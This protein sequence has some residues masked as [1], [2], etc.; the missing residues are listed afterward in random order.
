[1]LD[2][3]RLIDR[4]QDSPDEFGRHLADALVRAYA[5]HG[6]VVAIADGE[7]AP[8]RLKGVAGAAHD[9]PFRETASGQF[10]AA[11]AALFPREAIACSRHPLAAASAS[12]LVATST[13]RQ[14]ELRLAL[15]GERSLLAAAS[16][17]L[18]G[19]IALVW[20]LYLLALQ[21]RR[22]LARAALVGEAYKSR[23]PNSALYRAASLLVQLFHVGRCAALLVNLGG[24]S[25]DLRAVAP[26]P[27]KLR[28]LSEHFVALG[29]GGDSVV[30]R[31]LSTGVGEVVPSLEDLPDQL[32]GAFPHGEGEL[33]LL[34]LA[35]QKDADRVETSGLLVLGPKQWRVNS[36]TVRGTFL[37]EDLVLL[38]FYADILSILVRALRDRDEESHRVERILHGAKHMFTSVRQN[39][40][41]LEEHDVSALVDRRLQYLLPDSIALIDD[42]ASQLERKRL[43]Q[44][45]QIAVDAE[46]FRFYSDVL[47]GAI[48]FGR[49]LA[50]AFGRTLSVESADEPDARLALP[51]LR[52]NAQALLTVFRNLIHNSVKYARR[53]EAQSWVLVTARHDAMTDRIVAVVSDNGIGIM[54]EDMPHVF[55]DSFRGRNA[56]MVDPGGLGLGLSDCR[57]ILHKL[58]GSIAIVPPGRTRRGLAT[59]SFQVE[60]PVDSRL[61]LEP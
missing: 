8:V 36:A 12:T 53:D 3:I 28:N 35:A 17:E 15:A 27:A 26:R 57:E 10:E 42:L 37:W 23:D 55:E 41:L 59:T 51:L 30:H 52:S 22:L 7:N 1:M 38:E 43:R 25:I 16:A 4:T 56:R 44:L 6:A 29:H 40:S 61:V 49:S 21:Q 11:V 48:S 14:P 13:R 45:Q 47:S 54:E 20:R 46:P 32:H 2:V 60:L 18:G 34:P 9:A 39:L 33:L 58:G 24:S 31:V 50:R 19:D 5:L